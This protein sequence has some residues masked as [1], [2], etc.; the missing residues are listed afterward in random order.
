MSLAQNWPNNIVVNINVDASSRSEAV[1]IQPTAY[2][3]AAKD[4]KRSNPLITKK[5]TLL[6][7]PLVRGGC[8][9]SSSATGWKLR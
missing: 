3:V 4:R 7:V 2:A 9:E 6:D 1:D 8:D 5:N